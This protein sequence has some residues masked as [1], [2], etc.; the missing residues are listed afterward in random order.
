M[1]ENAQQ[2][3]GRSASTGERPVE[4]AN[5][6]EQP[7]LLEDERVPRVVADQPI[8]F[9]AIGDF[10]AGYPQDAYASINRPF[11]YGG[12][13]NSTSYWDGYPHYV[14]ADSMQVFPPV[15]YNDNPSLVF[16]SGYG[17]NPQMAYGQYTNVATPLPSLM[18]DRQLYSPHQNPFSQPYYPQPIPS[19]PNISSA[20]SVPQTELMAPESSVQEGFSGNMRSSQGSSYVIQFGSF[21]RGGLSQNSAYGPGSSN[22]QGEFVP[23]NFLPNQSN[24]PEADVS[25]SSVTSQAAHPQPVGIL[26]SYE[27]NVRQRAAHGLGLVPSSSNIFYPDGGLYESTNFGGASVS[28][29]GAN[30]RNRLILEKGKIRERDRS[31][32]VF[33]TDSSNFSSDRNRGPRASKPKGQSTSGQGVS[34]SSRK[35]DASNSVVHFDSYNQPDF[36]TDYENA[37]FFI[38]KSYSEDNVH[39]S[40]KYSVWASTALGNRKLD[41]AYQKAKEIETN[42]PIFLC[43][44]VNASSQF[45]GV[46][47]M[48]GP[49]NFEKDAEYWQQDRWSGLFPVKW[50]IIKDVPNSL[51]RHILLENNENKPV[52]HSRDTQEVNLEQGIEML[53][54]FKSYDAHTSILEDFDF[55][56]QRERASKERKARQQ[57]CSTTKSPGSEESVNHVSNS[58]SQSL[59]LEESDR[60]VIATEW[61]DNSR[62]E[63]GAHCLEESGEAVEPERG[64]STTTGALV[65]LAD[66][67][68]NQ[69]SDSFAQTLRLEGSIKELRAASS[70]GTDAEVSLDDAITLMTLESKK[71][72]KELPRA[73]RINSPRP[74]AFVS[75]VDYP[76]GQISDSSVQSPQ[77][78]ESSKEV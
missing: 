14:N 41:A 71:N 11:Y 31:S 4:P 62:T 32:G 27:H 60:E 8:S 1:A 16:S 6:R 34:S 46:A 61:G 66:V 12:Y 51:F 35:S 55:Y 3:R 70:S 23:P 52:T 59:Q 25:L 65:S 42:C 20:V 5:L 68:M 43:F 58:F 56:E 44:S 30:D 39:R 77:L 48:V 38:I 10:N 57:A 75:L 36:V 28:P 26:G 47:E 78:E 53:K 72:N 74:D 37:K 50:H 15:I 40:I 54:I 19:V 24:L 45:C 29:L 33:S 18:V 64:C 49:V 67:S 76:K 73:G 22:F 9:D 2:E 63:S 17:F 21:G 7:N 13:D 69:M